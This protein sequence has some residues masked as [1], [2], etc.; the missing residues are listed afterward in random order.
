M[1]TEGLVFRSQEVD[2]L[3][4]LANA[5]GNLTGY[6][7]LAY[8]LIQNADDAD[9]A[10]T[11][12]FDVRAE[13]LVVEN[14]GLFTDCERQELHD[15]PWLE[16]RNES[17][18][19]H[20]FRRIEGGAK[21]GREN[22]TGA[23]GVGFTAVYQ[24]TDEPRLISG[25]REWIVRPLAAAGERIQE[26]QVAPPHQGTRFVLPWQRE[27]S[28]LRARLRVPPAPDDV[29]KQ[30]VADVR[31]A[32][33]RAM[34]FL[35]RLR[36]VELKEDGCL[37]AR[38]ERREESGK[39]FIRSP[40]GESAFYLWVGAFET[41]ADR[42][43]ARYPVIE[44]L[45]S[46]V[47]KV[48][49]PATGGKGAERGRIHAVLPTSEPSP[50]AFHLNADFFPTTDRKRVVLEDD[51]QSEWNRAALTA[52]AEVFA[53]EVPQRGP[54]LGAERLWAVLES[55]ARAAQ[56]ARSGELDQVFGLFW[57]RV[58]DRAGST[59]IVLT[60]TGEWRVP[61]EVLLLGQTEE[62]DALELFETLGLLVADREVRRALYSLRQLRVDLERDIGIRELGV[63]DILRALEGAGLEEVEHNDLIAPPLRSQKSR[64]QLWDELERLVSRTRA[65]EERRQ[66]IQEVRRSAT[67]PRE[68]GGLC[69]WHAAYRARGEIPLQVFGDVTSFLDERAL[70]GRPTLTGLAQEFTV[71]RAAELLS[72]LAPA[73]LERLDRVRVLRWLAGHTGDLEGAGAK[74]AIARLRKVPIF[75]S[76]GGFH[77]LEEV[78][79]PGDFDD[80]LGITKLI[81]LQGEP[82]LRGLAKALGAEELTFSEYVRTHVPRHLQAHDVERQQVAEIVRL[83]SSRLGE[84]E[85]DDDAHEALAG[86]PIVGCADGKARL[87]SIVYF[88]TAAVRRVLGDDVAFASSADRSMTEFYEWLGVAR[89][90]RPA[91]LLRRVPQLVELR[92]LPAEI[93]VVEAIVSTLGEQFTR[94]AGESADRVIERFEG[95]YIEL[96]EL[97]WLPA[98]GEVAR[99]YRPVDLYRRSRQYLFASQARF[100]GIDRSIED[101]NV[102]VL[103]ELLGMPEAPTVAQVVEHLLHSARN[104][105]LVNTEVYTYLNQHLADSGA[106]FEID[107]LRG[108]RVI[109][110]EGGYQ[111]PG[112]VFWSDHD[113]APFRA[114]LE[115][116]D[117]SR[118]RLLFDAIGVKEAPDYEDAI[119]LIAEI[120]RSHGSSEPLEAEGDALRV[121]Q[122]CWQLLDQAL[123]EGQVDEAT[124]ESRLGEIAG[125]PNAALRLALPRRIF[126]EDLVGLRDVFRDHLGD[127]CIARPRAAWRALHAAGVRGLREAARPK[128]VSD[129]KSE[130][131]PLIR[132]TLDERRTE[133]ARLLETIFEGAERTEAVRRLDQLEIQKVS[134]L[135]VCWHLRVPHGLVKSEEQEL[136]AI[137]SGEEDAVYVLHRDG[138]V[139]SWPTLAREIAIAIA[140]GIDP[141]RFAFQLKSVL[142][143]PSRE[144]A[145]RELDELGV[146]RLH[147]ELPERPRPRAIG[148]P[149]AVRVAETAGGE[150]DSV[151]EGTD[152]T[153]LDVSEVHESSGGGRWSTARETKLP[154]R[155]GRA[156]ERRRL[157]QRDRRGVELYVRVS[158]ERG[159]EEEDPGRAQRLTEVEAA[160]IRAALEFERRQNRVP[161]EMPPVHPGYDI[162][163]SLGD[164]LVRVIEVKAR[165]GAWDGVELT[166][167][168]FDEAQKRRDQYWLYVVENAGA[169]DEKIIRI[170]D[171]AGAA[172]RFIFDR[173]WR[174]VAEANADD[175][176]DALRERERERELRL[177]QLRPIV[178]RLIDMGAPPPKTFFAVTLD[179]ADRVLEVEAAWPDRSIALVVE[180]NSE[181][182][183]ALAL[184]GWTVACVGEI[185]IDELFALVTSSP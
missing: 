185:S 43:K 168:E 164:Q 78:L 177:D 95:E 85:G 41:E 152:E 126:V 63:V 118:W 47:V 147:D 102:F 57:A 184:S 29:T 104:D 183:D 100:L 119:G 34:L 65:Q 129:C 182:D 148:L 99:W 127:S 58:L 26:R 156:G 124:V 160:G 75:P 77:P 98:E 45:R 42:L 92:P 84:I 108:E 136:G 11:M 96:R 2:H 82:S 167:T 179:G 62:F 130:P 72:S 141:G 3:G 154:R 91:D 101:K 60:T 180:R 31:S 16:E 138:G 24:V 97:A 93:E 135:R 163:S 115:P 159:G 4:A 28:E 51:Y 9:G 50:F 133:T 161:V 144:E 69:R 117:F 44:K 10:T 81:D 169:P 39:V 142:T 158:G 67:A 71:E 134:D 1:K 131:D 21:R 121:L 37:V 171:P 61:G 35:R 157:K 64:E 12:T 175:A 14:D 52:A 80:P 139:S 6:A 54:E 105:E 172:T 107:R 90:P 36:L 46:P 56:Q 137:Y 73:D 181:R 20:S 18:D 116:G 19:F 112:H 23:F 55:V 123:S 25:Q 162:E 68:G 8:E 114:R 176:D 49:L 140:P 155:E 79:L 170:K 40:S 153:A 7:T 59:P 165:S 76:G 120:A 122:V 70:E 66:L 38:F 53:A 32:I 89:T 94:S 88:D 113:L 87:A 83:L 128:I 22:V 103:D 143:A 125:V 111:A 146:P 145:A 27:D 33:P 132:G 86:A 48:A 149:T 150:R 13:A 106:K 74:D 109:L 30:L 110:G 174:S 5:L 151:A 178:D 15:C 173:G 17:C 166:K